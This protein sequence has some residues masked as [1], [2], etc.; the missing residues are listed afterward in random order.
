MVDTPYSIGYI[1]T[2]LKWML[3]WWSWN[4]SSFP[5]NPWR[6]LSSSGVVLMKV[7]STLYSMTKLFDK[8]ITKQMQACVGKWED[9]HMN[10]KWDRFSIDDHVDLQLLL[11]PSTFYNKI[12]LL[13]TLVTLQGNALDV[14]WKAKDNLQKQICKQIMESC[15]VTWML[16][17]NNGRGNKSKG[18]S[19]LLSVSQ[20]FVLEKMNE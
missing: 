8:R 6:V 3:L 11:P 5:S 7:K 4:L 13:E 17:N 10:F 15:S 2:V 1:L 20:F 12:S 16:M 19:S 14:F 9:Y 18:T